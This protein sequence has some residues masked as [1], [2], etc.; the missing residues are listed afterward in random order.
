MKILFINS[1]QFKQPWPILPFGLC[2]VSAA[3]KQAGHHVRI[4]DLC[5]SSDTEK[6]I[7]AAVNEFDP[8]V[9]GLSIRNIDNSAGYNTEF[10]LDEIDANTIRPL[11]N[12][13]VGPIVIGGPSVGISGR[14]MLEYLDLNY[15]IRGDGEAGMVEFLNR[16]ESGKDLSQ[17][18]G[19][20]IR[21]GGRIETENPAACV[22]DLDS[23]FSKGNIFS[24]IDLT[25]YNAFGTHLPV[26]TKRGCALKC[27]YCTY[28]RIEGKRFRLRDPR[29]IADQIETMVRNTGI[30]KI[31]FTDSTFN[32]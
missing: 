4:L 8:D 29:R 7:T 14:E 18:P 24:D 31:E 16:L 30:N 10:F 25:P 26:Q 3:V 27:T 12:I 5:F 28:N 6:D 32:L 17:T 15:A 13:F 11:K 23:V 19:L 9:V 2:C 20:I 21:Q 1:N 22:S